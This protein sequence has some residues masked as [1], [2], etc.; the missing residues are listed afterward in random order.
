M[1]LL[2]I[3]FGMKRIGFAIGNTG[4]GTATPID[5]VTRKNSKQV[6]AYIKELVTDYDITGIV[7]GYPL[8]MD[9]T[10][11][12]TTEQVEHFTRRLKKT[13]EPSVTVQWVDER[14]SSFEAEEELKA[15]KLSLK[16]RKGIVDSMSAV[17]ILR[18]F[19]ETSTP[20]E[21]TT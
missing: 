4:I 5:P 17:V 1:K 15:I 6:I 11:S 12:S 2:A 9:G 21:I 20:V 3:D 19:M 7:V 8:H 18:R 10:R 13:F 14:L 16:K